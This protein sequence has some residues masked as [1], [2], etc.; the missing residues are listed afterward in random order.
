MTKEKFSGILK[1]YDFSDEQIELLWKT[2]PTSDLD[3]KLL[4]K[5]VKRIAPIKD[6]LVQE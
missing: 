2:K 6:E 5:T 3:E 4:R 1:E